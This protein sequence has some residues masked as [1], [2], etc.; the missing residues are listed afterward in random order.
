LLKRGYKLPTT[1]MSSQYLP[2][3]NMGWNI[4]IKRLILITF[5]CIFVKNIYYVETNRRL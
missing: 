5:I 3:R 1:Q 4:L 2:H